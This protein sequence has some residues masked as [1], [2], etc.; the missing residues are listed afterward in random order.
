[1]LQRACSCEPTAQYIVHSCL[2]S[3]DALASNPALAACVRRDEHEQIGYGYE[4]GIGMA[5]G[6]RTGQQVPAQPPL[7]LTLA[8]CS[9]R[10]SWWYIPIKFATTQFGIDTTWI[11]LA[12]DTVILRPTTSAR[13][14]PFAPFPIRPS[15]PPSLS[16]PAPPPS[17]S[18]DL[19]QVAYSR[20]AACWSNLSAPALAS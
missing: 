20:I 18:P 7:T 12:V 14:V 10:G 1:V 17:P 11:P 2:A 4:F 19:L 16:T 8:I 5:W 15:L 9:I 3:E 13:S 6:S